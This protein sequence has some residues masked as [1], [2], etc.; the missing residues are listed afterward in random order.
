MGFQTKGEREFTSDIC[1]DIIKQF[2][3]LNVPI[4]PEA[5]YMKGPHV[6]TNSFYSLERERNFSA[7]LPLTLVILKS[8]NKSRR[9]V[10][11]AN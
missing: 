4:F 7:D 10:I 1:H 11:N 6:E 5:G 9:S 3:L 8:F 2:F